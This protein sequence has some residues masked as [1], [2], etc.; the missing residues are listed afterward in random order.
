V[1]LRVLL[2]DDHEP[3]LAGI[4]YALEQAG[5]EVVAQVT[6]GADAVLA[7]IG[8]KPDV[9]LLDVN[10]PGGGGIEA[11]AKIAR[12][13]PDT[14]VV[15]LSGVVRDEEFFAAL[16]VGARGFLLKDTDPDRLSLALEGV[17]KGEAA[18]PRTLV[19]RLID[20]FRARET[21]RM[22]LTG[23][24]GERPSEREWEVL[25]LMADGLSTRAVAER[26]G[27]AEV[28]VRRHVSAAV[29]KLGVADRAAALELFRTAGRPR[30]PS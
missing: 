10:M 19:A 2:A 17:L 23:P 7:A 4:T 6:N 11:A 13:V 27:I 16:L 5:M 1:T 28:T 12:E 22:P 18:I 26:L 24:T 21:S 8:T 29:E 20:E 25:K 3:T 30:P 9:A 15:M 14:A